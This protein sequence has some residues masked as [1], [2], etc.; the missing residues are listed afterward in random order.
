MRFLRTTPEEAAAAVAKRLNSELAAGRKVLWLVSGGSQTPYNVKIMNQI[1]DELSHNLIV[2]LADERYGPPGH[3]DSNWAKLMAAG[4]PTKEAQLI[5]VLKEGLGF[6]EN[7]AHYNQLAKQAFEESNAIIGQLGMGEDG[8][9]AGILPNSPATNESEALVVGY[10]APPLKRMSLTFSALRQIKAAYVL[11]F[12]EPK[13]PALSQLKADKLNLK[14]QPA[15]IFTQI[16]EAYIYNDQLGDVD[17]R[18][19]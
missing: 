3:K 4:F 1:T 2:M 6:E 16:P 12:G 17:G 19:S 14:K 8:H 5:P 9:T 11:A 15:R 10:E 7:T 18:P 13:K